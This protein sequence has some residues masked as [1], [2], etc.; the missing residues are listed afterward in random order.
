M[1]EAEIKQS[2]ARYDFLVEMLYK[3]NEQV[4]AEFKNDARWFS[5][6]PRL[7][8]KFLNQAFTLKIL[9]NQKQLELPDQSVRSFE[10]LSALYAVLR[11]QFETHAVFYHLFVPAS[12]ME[13]NILR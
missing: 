10:D 8:I 3:I 12:H 9:L 7:V 2:L 13:E 5:F 4:Y 1:L 11:M 6:A